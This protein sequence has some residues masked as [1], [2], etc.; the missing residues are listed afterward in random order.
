M[1]RRTNR[2]MVTLTGVLSAVGGLLLGATGC[3][4]DGS[5]PTYEEVSFPEGT[6]AI[7]EADYPGVNDGTLSLDRFGAEIGYVDEDGVRWMLR[8]ER[9]MLDS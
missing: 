1:K 5:C 8:Y 3:L 9:A 6:Y 7:P 4:E 2:W